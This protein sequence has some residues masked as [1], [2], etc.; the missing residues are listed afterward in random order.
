[1]YLILHTNQIFASGYASTNQII[2]SH[3]NYVMKL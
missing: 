2:V 1:M 3:T